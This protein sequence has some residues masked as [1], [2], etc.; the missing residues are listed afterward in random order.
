MYMYVYF[1]QVIFEVKS[2]VPQVILVFSNITLTLS[3][4]D[5]H[6]QSEVTQRDI[7]DFQEQWKLPILTI[8][9][10]LENSQSD[11]RAEINEIAPILN[12]MCDQL[13]LRDQILAG[14]VENVDESNLQISQC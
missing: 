6:A 13:W 10:V 14:K 8:R 5:K 2:S 9:N 12:Y 3:R 7:R 11:P 1:V 4:I